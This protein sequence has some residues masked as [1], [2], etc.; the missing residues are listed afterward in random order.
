MPSVPQRYTLVPMQN[1]SPPATSLAEQ[2]PTEILAEMVRRRM[3]RSQFSDQLG[4]SYAWVASRLS[5]ETRITLDDLA[6]IAAG[7]GMDATELLLR[8][9]S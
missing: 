2:V 4:V 9:A 7:L 1:S 8:C 6:R 5:G 3:T